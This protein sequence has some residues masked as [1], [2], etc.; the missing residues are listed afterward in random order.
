MNTCCVAVWQNSADGR[1]V[2]FQLSSFSIECSVAVQ[3]NALGSISCAATLTENLDLQGKAGVV[4]S[5][6]VRL[7]KARQV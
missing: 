2:R 4:E 7:G 5:R 1:Q 3:V 6:H